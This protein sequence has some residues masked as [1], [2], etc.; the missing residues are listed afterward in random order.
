MVYNMESYLKGAAG[1]Y[2]L[3]AQKC[4][5]QPI[6]L[7]HVSAPL[8][9]RKTRFIAPPRPLAQRDLAGLA[10]G[11]NIPSQRPTSSR[12]SSNIP[13]LREEKEADTGTQGTKDQ[14]DRNGHARRIS[15]PDEYQERKDIAHGQS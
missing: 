15:N 3:V 4:V 7:K 11:V 5:D 13:L 9:Y 14:A 1:R 8:S 12:K 10:P 6:R 2:I